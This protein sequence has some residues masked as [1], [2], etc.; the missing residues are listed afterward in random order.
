LVA[1]LAMLV[2]LG[3]AGLQWLLTPRGVKIAR[4]GA[5]A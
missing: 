4:E 1:S 2:E 3:L 5:T